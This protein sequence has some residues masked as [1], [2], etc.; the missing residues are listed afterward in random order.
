MARVKT[1]L[2]SITNRP[3]LGVRA[4]AAFVAL[5]GV[6]GY[7]VPIMIGLGGGHTAGWRAGALLVV[8]GSVLL[9]WCAAE[10]YRA[11]KGT[12][13]PWAP[14]SHL[15]TSG[16]YQRSRNP[17]YVA[18]LMLTPGWAVWLG[19]T[20]VAVYSAFLAV[21]FYFRVLL[22]E[23]PRLATLFPSEWPLY[24]ANVR[25][26]FQECTMTHLSSRRLSSITSLLLVICVILPS[27]GRSLPV[28][29]VAV[30]LSNS[31]SFEYATVS[32][33]EEGTRITTQPQHAE[34]SEIRRDAE[35]NWVATYVY[36]PASGYVGSD[37]VQLEILANAD[38]VGPPAVRRLTIQ[39]TVHE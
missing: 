35:T 24:A 20:G 15:V 16:P 10:F 26:W 32:G 5:P 28:E 29:V 27:C 34:V 21:A 31:D 7:A 36:R 19:S 11:G 30:S 12:L 2:A 38:G 25:R 39:F 3:G 37:F 1:Q 22:Y 6:V 8:S 17:M 4:V 14:P 18:V 13:A 33:D 23:E 9:I